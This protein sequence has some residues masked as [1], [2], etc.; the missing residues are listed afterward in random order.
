MKH[1]LKGGENGRGR[2]QRVKGK[3]TASRVSV[4]HLD[5][6]LVSFESLLFGFKFTRD[7]SCKYFM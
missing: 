6:S 7:I 1:L 3:G 5:Q 2:M 4:Y